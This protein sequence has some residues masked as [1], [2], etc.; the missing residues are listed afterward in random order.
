MMALTLD[1]VTRADLCI[2]A[3]WA[4]KLML[5][6]RWGPAINAELTAGV[7]TWTFVDGQRVTTPPMMDVIES[8]LCGGSVNRALVRQL[9]RQGLLPS[10]FRA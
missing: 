7:S 2:I 4:F 3:I 9:W 10:A 8:T 5:G 6:P 1:S